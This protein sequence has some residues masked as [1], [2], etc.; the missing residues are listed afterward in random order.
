ML[1][2]HAETPEHPWW[3]AFAPASSGF[4]QPAAAE[5]AEILSSWASARRPVEVLDVAC[6]GGLYSLT[7]IERHEHAVATLLDWPNVLAI[8]RG[9]AKERGLVERTRFIEGDVFEVPLGGPYDLIVASHI[10][11]HFSE[12]RFLELLRRLADA[13]KPDGRLVIHE[14]TARGS[15]PAEEVFPRLF[16]VLML[17][18]TREGEAY[19][20]SFYVRLLAETGFGPP[21]VHDTQGPSR[22]LIAERAR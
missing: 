12:E 2:E 7:F 6:G 8:T 9:T 5:L 16:S 22:F 19:P 11:H 10:F 14:M 18:W 4:V 1:D 17:V 3:E 15:E 20:V 21:E 13:L